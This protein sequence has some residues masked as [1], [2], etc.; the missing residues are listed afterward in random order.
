MFIRAILPQKKILEIIWALAQG[1]C[2]LTMSFEELQD[3]VCFS[4]SCHLLSATYVLGTL[5]HTLCN[6]YSVF[7]FVTTFVVGFSRNRVSER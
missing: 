7:I 3:Q 4:I 2:K 6:T 5:L 1:L